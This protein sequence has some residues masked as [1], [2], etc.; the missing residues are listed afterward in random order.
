M[1]EAI[2]KDDKLRRYVT[3]RSHLWFFHV[4]LKNHGEEDVALFQQEMFD[5][6]EDAHRLVAV[7]AFRGSGKSTIMNLSYALWAVL[8]IQRK[9]FVLIVSRTQG[10]S[11][12]HFQNIKRE[13]E[14]NEYLKKD[15]G[16]FK[17]K[18]YKFGMSSLTIPYLNARIVA[19]CREQ[20]IRG[21]RHG[22]RRPDLIICDDI[23]D[24]VAAATEEGRRATYRWLIDEVFLAG[25]EHTKMII[26]G[27]LLNKESLMMK[28]REEIR[29]K[30]LKGIFRAYPFADD[31]YRVLWPERFSNQEKIAELR[32]MTDTE[33]WQ[34][35]YLLRINGEDGC[36][37]EMYD[38]GKAPKEYK[39]SWDEKK[40]PARKM[41]PYVIS[42]PLVTKMIM[43]AIIFHTRE[44]VEKY[45]SKKHFNFSES[46]I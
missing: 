43:R 29:A 27:N 2:A 13:L 26:L 37:F 46:E 6:T 42:A 10:Q 40:Y 22:A 34:K 35:E 1:A 28:L 18:E 21:I 9:K 38:A 33:G 45:G 7:M 12:F 41:G 44:E 16:P 5:L 32:N 14:D 31:E 4:F 15:M 24:S 3:R 19:V 23:E 36:T 8:G 17:A 20:S 11:K 39:S 25:D 30:K